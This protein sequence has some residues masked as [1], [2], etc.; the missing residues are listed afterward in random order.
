ML[1]ISLSCGR[2]PELHFMSKRARAGAFACAGLPPPPDLRRADIQRAAFGLLVEMRPGPRRPAAL[3][4]DA[5]AHALV[6]RPKLFARLCVG[7]G[8]IA[9]GMQA[10]GFC[11]AAELRIGALAEIREGHETPRIAADN[12]Q[13]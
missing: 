13:H 3:G 10:G 7:V 11:G 12:S 4:A 1:R 9:V 6:M 5:V 2:V 8:D